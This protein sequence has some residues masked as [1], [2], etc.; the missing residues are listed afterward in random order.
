MSVL[1]GLAP[2]DAAGLLFDWDG[3]LVDSQDANCRAMATALAEHGVTLEPAWFN[4]RT[5]LS[6]AEMVRALI[7]ERGLPLEQSVEDIVSSRDSHFLGTAAEISVHA[8][9]AAVAATF[10]GRLPMAVASGGT[11]HIIES[12]LRHLS[13]GHRFSAVVTRDDVAQGKP[14]PDIFLR[15]AQLLGVPPEGCLVYEDSEEGISA[16]HA[17][18]MRVIDVRPFTR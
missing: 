15:A 7:V 6:S 14:A 16:A 17:A 8:P 10:H 13:I 12:T 4:A 18:G 5:G 1:A 3:T 11:R 2:G 9:I